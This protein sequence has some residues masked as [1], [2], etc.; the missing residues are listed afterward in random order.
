[1][2]DSRI[3]TNWETS[4]T[5]NY[6]LAKKLNIEKNSDYIKLLYSNPENVINSYNIDNLTCKN[7]S[8]FNNDSSFYHNYFN[9]KIMNE[10]YTKIQVVPFFSHEYANY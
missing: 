8:D 5:F 9:D 10:M 1:M 4:K 2:G 6:K 3:F 7:N